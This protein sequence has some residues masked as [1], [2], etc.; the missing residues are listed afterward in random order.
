MKR[1]DRDLLLQRLPHEALQSL[2]TSSTLSRRGAGITVQN[3]QK[4]VPALGYFVTTHPP[5]ALCGQ[6]DLG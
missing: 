4:R 2:S 1:I 6:G 3:A 5:F